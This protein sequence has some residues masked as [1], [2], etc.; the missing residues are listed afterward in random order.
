MTKYK[1][2]VSPGNGFYLAMLAALSNA[3]YQIE[4]T[5]QNDTVTT[6]SF[7]ATADTYGK[8]MNEFQ[9][10]TREQRRILEGVAYSIRK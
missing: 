7:F 4:A 2:N 3:A 9:P 6:V 8:I 5:K 1:V 10:R